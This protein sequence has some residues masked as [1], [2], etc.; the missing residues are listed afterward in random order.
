[1]ES[2]LE[3]IHITKRKQVLE[4]HRIANKVAVEEGKAE[5]ARL[6]LQKDHERKT[7]ID[8]SLRRACRQGDMKAVRLAL[9]AGANINCKGSNDDTPVMIASSFGENF[10]LKLLLENGADVETRSKSGTTA[11]HCILTNNK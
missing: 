10:V 8:N 6:K 7:S 2:A 11:K 5:L 1:M 3:P 4:E 9:E